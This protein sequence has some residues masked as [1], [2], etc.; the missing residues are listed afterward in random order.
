MEG[1]KGRSGIGGNGG[2]WMVWLFQP[3]E[4][5]SPQ[6]V[7][8]GCAET[9]V[10]VADRDPILIAGRVGARAVL[11]VFV[12]WVRGLE[13]AGRGRRSGRGM[14]WVSTGWAS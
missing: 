1:G 13:S 11:S 3:G 2:E 4:D 14:E 9:A 8:L 6:A 12:G 5:I 10:V 7:L